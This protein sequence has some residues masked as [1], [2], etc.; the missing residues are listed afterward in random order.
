MLKIKE[1][2]SSYEAHNKQYED[3]NSL[4]WHKKIYQQYKDEKIFEKLKF[5]KIIK[6]FVI[7][8]DLHIDI[9]SG[10][11]W[12]LGYTAPL[13][14]KVIGIEPSSAAIEI[15]KYFNKEYENIEHIN[16]GM[17]EG[18][19]KINVNIPV[20]I[21]TS[22]VLSHINDF[23]VKKFL[24]KVN[25]LPDS[26]I[27]FFQE[28]YGK[29]RQQYLWHIRN[30]EWW[31]KNLYD[32]DLNF[33]NNFDDGYFRG[34]IGQRVGK[35]NVKNKYKINIYEKMAWFLSGIPSRFKMFMRFC[36]IK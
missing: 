27:L 11:G 34:I 25:N 32:W 19:A 26:S 5:K 6:D 10:A 15:S 28:P 22:T 13:F 31:A 21:T 3:V 1:K 20:F 4:E 18:L 16:S 7:F 8:K 23:E 33:D 35:E 2:I 14:K 17:V 9:G 12:L 29:N 36:G 30:R 24:E